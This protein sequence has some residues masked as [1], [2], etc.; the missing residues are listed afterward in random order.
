MADITEFAGDP[1]DREEDFPIEG[2]PEDPTMRDGVNVWFFEENGDFGFPRLA[3]DAVGPE[4][5]NR[6]VWSTLVFAN[7]R[8]LQGVN[9]HPAVPNLDASGKP[10]TLGATALRFQCIDPM[11]KWHVSYEETITDGDV[12]QQIAGTL[13]AAKTAQVRLEADIT[14]LP[15]LW[16]QFFSDDDPRPEAGWMGRGWRY[17]VPCRVVGTLE[18]DGV[19]R[20]F[21][22]NG[23]FVR[24]KSKRA[25]S[26][27]FPGHCWLAASFPDGRAFG[28]NVYPVTEGSPVYNTGYIYK[29]GKAY[30]AR[31]V[32]APW[33]RELVFSG[34][35]MSVVLESEL[36]LTRIEGVSVL[37]SFKPRFVWMGGLN[38]NQGGIRFRW[39]DQ[40][41]IGMTERSSPP[42][43]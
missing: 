7:R 33:L 31:V 41:T 30:E 11:R 17:E 36:G 25:T 13:D 23:N 1:I 20:E 3:V 15:P 42:V 40:E 26:T 37:S 16:S 8:L 43:D 32:E 4:W 19:S 18:I 39:D 27:D 22:A 21:R 2:R 6:M 14:L 38:L 34:E 10:T 5:D 24:R 9:F 12:D 28:C 35:D 29:D